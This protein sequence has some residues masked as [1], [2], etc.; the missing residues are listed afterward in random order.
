MEKL[1]PSHR[2][3]LTLRE[4]NE[5]SYGEIADALDLTQGTV[6]SR[7]C[8]AREQLCRILTAGGNKSAP[9]TSNQKKRR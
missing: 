1:S 3:I 2:E 5:L 4:L 7:L 9:Y 8:R 6:K